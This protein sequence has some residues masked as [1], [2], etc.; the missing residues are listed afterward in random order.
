MDFYSAAGS[1]QKKRRNR[2]G[3]RAGFPLYR[4]NRQKQQT[5]RKNQKQKTKP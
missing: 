1:N 2:G 5:G 4:M 3:F